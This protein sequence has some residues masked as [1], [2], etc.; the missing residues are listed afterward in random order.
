MANAAPVTFTLQEFAYVQNL[1]R[2]AVDAE[3]KV[4]PAY[5]GELSNAD[6]FQAAELS[7]AESALNNL[8]D[9]QSA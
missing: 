3:V 9:A 1:L 8:I 4:N 5:S 6:T 2:A 7:V